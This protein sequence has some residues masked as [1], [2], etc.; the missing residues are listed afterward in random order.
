MINHGSG[1][2]LFIMAAGLALFFEGI[3]Y[4][5]MPSRM[6]DFFRK[7]LDV[8]DRALRFIGIGAMIIGLL[9]VYLAKTVGEML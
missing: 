8:P 7:A 4:F 9:I 2:W 6:K 1:M 5:I 3:P